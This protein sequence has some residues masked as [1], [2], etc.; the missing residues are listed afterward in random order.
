MMS[1]VQTPNRGGQ[2]SLRVDDRL[3][4]TACR[5]G[6]LIQPAWPWS[7]PRPALD[8]SVMQHNPEGVE[9]PTARWGRVPVSLPRALAPVV[10]R[11]LA[12]KERG[13]A[14]LQAWQR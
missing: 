7:P 14:R 11:A 8:A 1:G 13:S 3:G 2:G 6:R 4:S 9:G 10:G 12:K 5:A